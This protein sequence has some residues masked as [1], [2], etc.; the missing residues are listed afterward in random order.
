[1]H[2][3]LLKIEYSICSVYKFFTQNCPNYFG[4][5]YVPLEANGVHTRSSYQKLNVLDRKAN[6]GQKA[7]S[8]VGPSLWNNLNKTEKQ[9]HLHKQIRTPLFHEE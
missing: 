4:E 6:V 1:M 7:L 9:N 5:I 3:I 8:Y 2:K